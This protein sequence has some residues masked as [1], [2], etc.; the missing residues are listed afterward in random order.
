MRLLI[1]IIACALCGSAAAQDEPER[2]ERDV[3]IEPT[4]ILLPAN[5]ETLVE[6]TQRIKLPS[7]VH[8]PSADAVARRA[9]GL[10]S[11]G[12]A[13]E[14]GRAFGAAA[15][16]ASRDNRESVVRGARGTEERPRPTPEPP[17]RP[18]PPNR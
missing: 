8:S 13:R 11:K 15:A 14:N 7:A 5:A 9:P 1:T 3:E 12:T 4:M 6:V 17:D 18:A 2:G 10:D 16:A